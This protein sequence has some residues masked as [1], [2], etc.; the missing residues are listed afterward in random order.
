M[1][2]NTQPGNLGTEVGYQNPATANIGLVLDAE[3]VGPDPVTGTQLTREVVIPADSISGQTSA[4]VVIPL[5][6]KMFL[7]LRAIRLLLESGATPEA[8]DEI[9]DVLAG[10]VAAD[11]ENESDE[12]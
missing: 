6:A 12:S 10:D 2:Q 3:V 7:E 5:L 9:E 1:P 11:P 8:I 4:E